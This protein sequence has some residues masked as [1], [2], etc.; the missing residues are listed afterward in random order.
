MRGRFHCGAAG[1][2]WV[3]PARGGGGVVRYEVHVM[4]E[5]QTSVYRSGMSG[6]YGQRGGERQCELERHHM[7]GTVTRPLGS[8][9]PIIKAKN[10]GQWGISL[11][12]PG[13]Q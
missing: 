10:V 12:I 2:V 1:L 7:V 9:A 4:L 11:S 6:T 13:N 8:T 3:V 5:A